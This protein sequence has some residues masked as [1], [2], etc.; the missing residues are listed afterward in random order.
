M[1][2]TT[3][4]ALKL[5][6]DGFFSPVGTA[7]VGHLRLVRRPPTDQELVEDLRDAWEKSDDLRI[8]GIL[9]RAFTPHFLSNPVECRWSV[10]IADGVVRFV[11]VDDVTITAYSEAPAFPSEEESVEV[12]LLWGDEHI[13]TYACYDPITP[14]TIVHVR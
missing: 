5:A 8:S 3:Q 1:S 13:L 2:A 11:L 6:L 10:D 4:T 7:K 9:D 12:W 14:G